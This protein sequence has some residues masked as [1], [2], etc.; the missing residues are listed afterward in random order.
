[1]NPDEFPS[2]SETSKKSPPQDEPK[3]DPVVKGGVKRR[4]RS[5]R[6]QFTETFIAG[7]AKSA[8]NWV[9]FEVLLPGVR[10]ILAE[11]V[12]QGVD[13]LI[14]GRNSSRRSGSMFH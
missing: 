5:L 14:F 10:E 2:N 8:G 1:M 7:D 12:Y 3:V 4:R 11:S 13:K 6:R 9:V